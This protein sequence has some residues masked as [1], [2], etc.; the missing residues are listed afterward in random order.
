MLIRNTD[1]SYGEPLDSRDAESLS[2][3]A[4]HNVER[5]LR[6][7]SDYAPTPL[8]Q[9]PALSGDLDV[10]AIYVKDEGERLGL[11]SFKALGGAYAL[12]L[13]VLEESERQLGRPPDFR[14]LSSSE[15]RAIAAQM[16]FGCA[17]DGNHGRSV[18]Y[19]AQLVG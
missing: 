5:F 4:A 17:T 11:G 1:A 6:H 2:V 7:H 9:L 13:L 3:A 15:V 19:G 8:L 14:D 18:A 12:I 16:T 10:S